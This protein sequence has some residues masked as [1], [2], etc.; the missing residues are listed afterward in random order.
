[1]KALVEYLARALVRNPDEVRVDE[2]HLG[3]RVILRLHVADDDKGRVIGREG[4][5][6][7]AIRSLVH[8]AGTRAG[9]RT[10]LDID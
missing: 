3:D 1:V 9:V 7:N 6:A 8:V 10:T 5:I 2:E 4:R